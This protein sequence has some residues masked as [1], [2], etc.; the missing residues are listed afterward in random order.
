MSRGLIKLMSLAGVPIPLKQKNSHDIIEGCP[1]VMENAYIELQQF[2]SE[3][4]TAQ[5]K[6]QNRLRSVEDIAN[7]ALVGYSFSLSI[8][9]CC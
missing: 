7:N 3:E 6:C 5:K 8:Q 2:Y 9:F 4:R 1:S